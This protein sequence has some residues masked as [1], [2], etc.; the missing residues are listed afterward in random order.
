MS[1]STPLMKAG[2]GTPSSYYFLQHSDRT[3]S[4]DLNRS[5]RDAD[6]GEELEPLPPGTTSEEFASRPVGILASNQSFNGSGN[7][8]N[9]FQKLFGKGKATRKGPV[10]ALVKERKVPIKIEPKVF[11]S[12]ERTFLA[13]LHVSIMLAGASIAIVAFADS[14]PWSQMY[15]VLLLPVAIAFICYAMM[16]YARRSA[17]IRNKAPGPYEDTV[18]PTVLGSMLILSI[19]A[20]FA[21]KLYTMAN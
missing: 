16:Q 8:G 21:I 13:W 2:G 7:S 5:S 4:L 1:E 12:N 15:G 18:G 9:F 20:Q 10:G 19:L 3:D 17:M 11:F 6:G 14:N